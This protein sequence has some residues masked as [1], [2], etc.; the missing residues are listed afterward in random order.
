[1]PPYNKNRSKVA[2]AACRARKT[3]CNGAKPKCSFCQEN[4]CD[5]KYET[6]QGPSLE[7]SVESILQKLSGIEK[8]LGVQKEVQPELSVDSLV[9]SSQM[10]EP[11][12][13]PLL[14]IKDSKFARI[15][16][17]KDIN[18]STIARSVEKK[19]NVI[20]N[21]G[22]VAIVRH[23]PYE[24][25]KLFF[26]HSY[27]WFPILNRKDIFT[28]KLPLI[29]NTVKVGNT[30]TFLLLMV[31]AIGG[32]N[33]DDS[34][35]L[36]QA[37]EFHTQAMN[38]LSCV[39]EEVSLQAIQC[40]IL[41]VMFYGLRVMPL[42]AQEYLSI[43]SV[44]MQN[45]IEVRIASDPKNK[46]ND[47]NYGLGEYE[48]RAFWALFIFESEY[49]GTLHFSTGLTAYASDMKYPSLTEEP[50]QD[51]QCPETNAS[52]MD[53][54]GPYFLAEIGIRK[55][56]DRTSYTFNSSEYRPGMSFAPIVAKEIQAQLQEWYS[57]LPEP[58]KFDLQ[59]HS[60]FH[61][62]K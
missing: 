18:L 50:Y 4:G 25:V 55:I 26:K 24:L 52:D 7:S 30:D 17:R 5:C 62:P 58:I 40:I 34:V 3:R 27:K 44:K 60:E 48:T 36:L 1:M 10:K 61:S 11:S 32:L 19:N 49:A 16:F 47:G 23:T 45:L 57:F 42:K 8:H 9:S 21:N 33:A 46:W 54:P 20:E 6:P 22:S 2:C 53:A 41:L 12:A 56:I 37:E 14:T 51:P 15:V 31:L 43:G 13:F 38:M 28:Q 35:G 39:M 59:P 29:H